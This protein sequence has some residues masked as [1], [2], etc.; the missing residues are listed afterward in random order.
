MIFLEVDEQLGMG[1]LCAHLF[2]RSN[3][4]VGGLFPK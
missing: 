1:W 3:E 4:D 2:I